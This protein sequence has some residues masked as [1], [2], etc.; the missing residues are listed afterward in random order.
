MQPGSSEAKEQ[1]VVDKAQPANLPVTFV[2]F[3]QGKRKIYVA[4]TLILAAFTVFSLFVDGGY[5]RLFSLDELLSCYSMALNQLFGITNLTSME[6]LAAE[7]QYLRVINRFSETMM[8]VVCGGILAVAG[9]LYQSSFKNPIASPSMLGISS[10][11]QLGDVILVILF[12]TAAASMVEQRYV[13]CYVCVI[14]MMLALFGISR[15]I[16]GKGRSMNVINLLLIAT[17]L[18]QLVGVLIT[19]AVTYLFDTVQLQ[20]YTE[21][22]ESMHVDLGALSWVLV[23]VT[24]L[25]G[26]VPVFAMRFRMNALN[27]NDDEMKLIG[28][29]NNRLRGFALIGGTIM[30][31]AAQVQMGTVAMLSLVVP[32]FCRLIFGSDFRTQIIDVTLVGAILLVGCKSVLGLLPYVSAI[33]PIG[34]VI[35][36]VVLP[37]FVWMIAVQQR[38]WNG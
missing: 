16:S 14:V 25:V 31:M 27:F 10:A 15:L 13:V 28:V 21:M 18:T 34:A 22:S 4:L 35:N 30:L 12:D 6:L 5:A 24:A 37:F 7:P 11:I 20:V 2:E 32:H 19:Y 9:L 8:T 3:K 26:F 1:A 29:D 36:F 33:L 23:L 38:G 17:V